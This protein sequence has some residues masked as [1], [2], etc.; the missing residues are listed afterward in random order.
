MSDL[1]IGVRAVSLKDREMKDDPA[2]RLL[3]A[4]EK[5]D[6]NAPARQCDPGLSI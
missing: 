2:Q 4:S 3:T 6:R 5:W 1:E